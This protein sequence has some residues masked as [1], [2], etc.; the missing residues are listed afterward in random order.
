MIIHPG[1]ALIVLLK[2]NVGSE[3]YMDPHDKKI[4]IKRELRNMANPFS[5]RAR[6]LKEQLKL[7]DKV[8]NF[9]QGRKT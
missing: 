1:N 3:K 5:G 7:L 9:F 4:E 8:D 2:K 6:H